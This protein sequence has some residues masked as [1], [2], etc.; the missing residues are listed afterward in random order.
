MSYAQASYAHHVNKPVDKQ[1]TRKNCKNCS[2]IKQKLK[3]LWITEKQ[4]RPQ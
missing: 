1:K 2:K 3:N 4:A